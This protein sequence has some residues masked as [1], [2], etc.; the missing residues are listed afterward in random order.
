MENLGKKL[1]VSVRKGVL[2]AEF[3]TA[4]GS[5]RTFNDSGVRSIKAMA[6]TLRHPK[7]VEFRLAQPYSEDLKIAVLRLTQPILK[8]MVRAKVG[9]TTRRVEDI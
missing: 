6:T 3:G 9:L 7:I 8:F 2:V 4:P 5:I 1:P